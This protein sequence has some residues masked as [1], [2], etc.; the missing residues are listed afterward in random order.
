MADIHIPK[1]SKLRI[2]ELDGLRGVLALWVALIH[3]IS[4]CGLTPH[5]F[6]LPVA[7]KRLWDES[8]QGAVD[9]FIILSGFVIT[10]LL[11]S[12]PQTYRQFMIGRFFRIYPVYFICLLLGWSTVG[13]VSFI[14]NHAPWQGTPSFQDWASPAAIAQAAHPVSHLLAH[15]TLLFGIIPEKIMP[16]ASVTL[17]GPAWSITLEWQYYLLAPLLARWIFSRA[18]LL[19]LGLVGAC[20]F[21][22]A[23][24][25][26]DSFLPLKLPLFLVGIGSYHLHAS[27]PRW[28]MNP[29]LVT[30]SV[31]V[32][33]VA[34]FSISWHWMAV[35]VWTLV[36]GSLVQN[37]GDRQSQDFW[38]RWLAGLR[39]LLLKPA[40]QWLGKI[41]YP[42]YL[43]HWP[44]IIFLLFG[45]LR[46]QPAITPPA[47]LGIMLA[48]GLPAILAA[49]W[50]LHKLIE[51]PLM[52]FGKN[53]TQ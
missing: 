44:V 15:L 17:L 31:V 50:G 47:A 6:N 10:Y 33:L 8:A 9:V 13:S 29:R 46:F 23:H 19:L 49:S 11:H 21:I 27:A 18:G 5:E 2:D 24:F 45:I 16:A 53:F 22:F 7:A 39:R 37:A 28:R 42:V 1:S 30:M 43:V 25:W 48:I 3:I 32:M 38:T 20:S 41:S 35:S 14:L 26:S 36:L 51:K 34:V 40:L 12:R 4:W 52:Q